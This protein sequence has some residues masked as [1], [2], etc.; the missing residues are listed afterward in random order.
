MLGVSSV[1]RALAL[2]PSWYAA[3][4]HF[5]RASSWSLGAIKHK[6][7]Q[8]VAS[9]GH[10]YKENGYAILIGDG[11]KRAKER[12]HMPGVKKL[13]QES[14]NSSKPEYIFGHLFGGI[15]VLAGSVRKWFCIP[16]FINLQ[17]GLQTILAWEQERQPSH[18]VQMIENGYDAAR[19]FGKSLLLL[20]LYFISV[21]ALQKL[22]E[23]MES[24]TARLHL[25][26]KAKKS[27]VAYEHP[28]PKKQGGEDHQRKGKV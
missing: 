21:P 2:D 25:I 20:D 28:W 15:G 11:V 23:C 17:D 10:I 9:S 6:W 13:F 27:C 3:M 12:R 7:F 1:I 14:E 18:V 8:A 22:A 24:G 19:V 5:L 26:T 16:L 4:L